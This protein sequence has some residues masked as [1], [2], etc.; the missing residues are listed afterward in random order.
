MSNAASTYAQFAGFAQTWGLAFFV[1]L[2]AL[3]VAYALKPSNK[4]VFD[5]AARMPLEED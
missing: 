5:R 4:D 1:T 2:F 3:A